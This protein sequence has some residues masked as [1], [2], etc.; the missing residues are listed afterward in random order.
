[1]LEQIAPEKL[2]WKPTPQEVP[3]PLTAP[4]SRLPLGNPPAPYV[5]QNYFIAVCPGDSDVSETEDGLDDIL[6]I[7]HIADVA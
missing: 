6:F 4:T 2:V 7:L 5:I 3:V 1:M